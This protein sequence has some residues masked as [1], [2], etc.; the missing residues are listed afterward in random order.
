[1]QLPIAKSDRRHGASAFGGELTVITV[2][3]MKLLLRL[4]M[5]FAQLVT[6][7]ITI[8]LRRSPIHCGYGGSGSG[9]AGES[10][11]CWTSAFASHAHF[12]G[13]VALCWP[14]ALF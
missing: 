4:D 12:A 7:Q 14:S 10:S 13:Q 3:S 9:I 2:S 11:F 8:I 1:M 5:Q 6:L